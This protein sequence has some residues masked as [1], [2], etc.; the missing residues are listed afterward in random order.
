M[1]GLCVLAPDINQCTNYNGDTG[2]CATNN[3]AC[4]F[5]RDSGKVKRRKDRVQKE[6]EMVRTIL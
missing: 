6:A 4:G 2:S 3:N 1:N 5:F